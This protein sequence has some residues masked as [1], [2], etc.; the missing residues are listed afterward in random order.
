M[1][2]F[3]QQNGDK[4]VDVVAVRKGQN[5]TFKMTPVQTDV[6]AER[7]PIVWG[8]DGRAGARRQVAFRHRALSRSLEEN[9]KYSLLMVDMIHKMVEKKVS[10]QATGWADRN[11]E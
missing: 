11:C 1:I 8:S 5:L 3:L 7:K 10:N 4:P 2:H 6:Q 9:K